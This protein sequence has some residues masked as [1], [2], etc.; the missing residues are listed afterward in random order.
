MSDRSIVTK[1]VASAC[2]IVSVLLL[3]GSF[4]LIRFEIQLVETFTN[5]HLKK[6]NQSISDREKADRISLRK[7]V[8]FNTEILTGISVLFLDNFNP[9]GLKQSL[10]S[11][12]NYPEIRAIKV[13]DEDGEPFAAAWKSPDIAVADALPDDLGFDKRFSV[14]TEAVRDGTKL[15][16]LQVYYTEGVLME[17]IAT[18]KKKAFDESENFR[19]TSEIRLKSAIVKQCIGVLLILLV[20]IFSL[21]VSLKAQ[22]LDPLNMISDIAHRLTDFDLSVRIDTQRNDEIGRLLTAIN[23]MVSEF[24]KIVSDV[25]SGGERLASASVQMTRNIGAVASAAEEISVNVQSVSEISGQMLQSSTAVASSIE[26]MSASMNEVGMNAHKGSHISDDAVTM[27]GK[28]GETMASLG[29]AADEIGDVTELIKRIA[30]KTTL[31][32]LNAD[33]EAASAGEAGR[34]FGVVANEIREFAR[35]STYAAEDISAR[36]TLMQEKTGHAV[37]AISDVSGIIND[38]S[39]SSNAISFS[40]EKQMKMANEIASNAG[41]ASIRAKNISI[42]MEELTKG[43]NEVSMNVGMAAGGRGGDM[44]DGDSDVLYMNASATQ[45]SELAGE[46]LELVSKFKVE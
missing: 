12:M 39:Q 18:A 14:D 7:N 17:K 22:V 13:T 36:I 31:L 26:E 21:T 23:N 27:A 4:A 43:A 20:L 1:I 15:G 6:I 29:K 44:K 41:Q 38:I 11:Y 2:G 46:L 19:N 33:I 28:A 40:L 37:K 35:Q 34:G 25:K 8:E 24:R 42:S 16:K 3:A 30:E 5:E 45:V 10:R 32:A 9:D